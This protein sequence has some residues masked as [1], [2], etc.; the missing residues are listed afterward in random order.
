MKHSKYAGT[1]SL[2]AQKKH[3]SLTG[4]ILFQ[5]NNLVTVNPKT[6]KKTGS[7]RQFLRIYLEMH[8]IF[9]NF[10]MLTAL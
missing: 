4:D 3:Q 2:I 7:E 10:F 8:F 6:G 5:A 1:I 9:K